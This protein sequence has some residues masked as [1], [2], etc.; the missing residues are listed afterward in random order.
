MYRD[1]ADLNAFYRGGL[2]RAARRLTL[3]RIRALWPDVS[4]RSVAGLGHVTPFLPV[5]RDEAERTI[6]LAPAPQG[7]TRWP[8][9]KPCGV[10]LTED[11][12]LPLPDESI[13]RMLMVHALEH[14]EARSATMR[15]VWRA[16]SAG[17]RLLV[18]VANRRG[19]WARADHTPFGHGHPF[20]EGQIDRLLRDS[21]F[22]PLRTEFA[23]YVPPIRKNL[24]LRSAPA[25][26]RI[27]RRWGLLPPGVLLVEASKQVHGVL[28][29]ARRAAGR[30]V[31]VP[32]AAAARRPRHV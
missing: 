1:V 29:A 16:L 8:E 6:A 28:P 32:D 31:F 20:N 27:G 12:A 30:R 10:C 14:S 15:E 23:L 3:A 17:G 25:W 21:M 2:G 9:G 22:T 11:F 7:A 24:S 4:G 18:A 19:L 5:F 26:E 13:D